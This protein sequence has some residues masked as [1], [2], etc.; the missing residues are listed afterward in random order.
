MYAKPALH[1]RHQRL[2]KTTQSSLN[3]IKSTPTWLI[4]I[5][6]VV[7]FSYLFSLSTFVFALLHSL[8]W[9]LFVTMHT[10]HRRCINLTRSLFLIL[11]S[12]I[13][14]QLYL[15]KQKRQYTY[16]VNKREN[17]DAFKCFLFYAK[18]LFSYE[19]YCPIL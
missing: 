4:A 15:A 11:N 7:L 6:F 1:I 16:R 2:I 13:R 9:I 18:Y 17:Q 3:Y 14:F 12:N 19:F 8:H 10:C 5:Y